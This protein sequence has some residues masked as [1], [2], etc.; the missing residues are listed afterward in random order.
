[1]DAEITGSVRLLGLGVDLALGTDDSDGDGMP[2]WWETKY[3][4]INGL[5]DAGGNPDEDALT[6]LEEYNAGSNPQAFDFLVIDAGEGNLFVLDT[7]GRW[8]DTDGD[9]IPDWWERLYTGNVTNMVANTD[10]D[11]DGHSNLEEFITKS[12]PSSAESVFRVM[13]M[14]EPPSG[15]SSN[16]VLTWETAVDRRYSVYT[17][18]D[19]KSVWPTGAVYQVDGDGAP[20]SYTNTYQNFQPRFYRIGV[21]LVP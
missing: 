14:E 16:W 17:H 4:L 1:M 21:E 2:D 13:G 7:G 18:T 11:G 20:K 12:S 8:T 19:L 15:D 9:G 3:G 5:D 6:N 10:D